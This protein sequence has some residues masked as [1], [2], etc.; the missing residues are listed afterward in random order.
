MLKKID[1]K[2]KQSQQKLK[3]K[4]EITMS[5]EEILVA[6]FGGKPQWSGNKLYKIGDMR[7]E[8]SGT[9][10]YKVG[11]ARIEYSGNQLYK[12]NGERV[13]WSGNNVYKIGDKRM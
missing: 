13:Q 2:T 4:E 1:N 8:Y 12:I 11:G 7:V 5:D 10:L 9:K 6:Y 3:R